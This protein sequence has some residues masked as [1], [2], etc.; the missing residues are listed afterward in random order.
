MTTIHEKYKEKNKR[1]KRVKKSKGGYITQ[2]TNAK[3][4][5]IA[6]DVSNEMGQLNVFSK[7]NE[8]KDNIESMGNT[9]N[10]SMKRAHM[11]GKDLDHIN[12]IDHKDTAEVV[13]SFS[14]L[15]KGFQNA[16][17]QTGNNIP[18]NTSSDPI[19]SVTKTFTEL[20]SEMICAFNPFKIMSNANSLIP[21]NPAAFKN[22][23]TD[24]LTKGFDPSN[25][26]LQPGDTKPI[27]TKKDD[28]EDDEDEDE[29][30][31]EKKKRRSR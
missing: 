26:Y 5:E 10:T 9:I 25:F 19:C 14:S 29:D 23:L 7:I 13:N 4:D 1:N 31:D 11:K 21:V 27:G 16:F 2:K 28:E 3:I 20:W 12:N 24:Q 22:Q 8:T 15:N 30:D 6:E 18:S 17:N